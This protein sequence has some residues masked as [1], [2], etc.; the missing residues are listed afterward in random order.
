MNK[1]LTRL[2][3]DRLS[4]TFVLFAFALLQL[5]TFVSYVVF[6]KDNGYLPSPF[7]YVKSDTFMD[8]FNPMYWS[9]N[10]G[11]YTEWFSVY[12]P[13]VFIILRVIKFF[14]TESYASIDP[15]ELRS[16]GFFLEI[17]LITLILVLT[18]FVLRQKSWNVFSKTEKILLFICF[19]MSAP[20]LFALERGNTIII[21]LFLLAYSLSNTISK[22]T[23]LTL[24]A[25][26]INIKPYFV[27]LTISYLI[28]RKWIDFLF[29]MGVAGLLFLVTGALI[30][31]NFFLFFSN[32]LNFSNS[33][34]PISLRE[35]MT[36]P[37]SISVYSLVLSSESFCVGRYSD[38]CE[39]L[40]FLPSII[41]VFKWFAIITG[42]TFLTR[43]YKC[44]SDEE[45]MAFLVVLIS[46]MSV[47]VGGYSFLL[48]FAVF[49]VI[50][51]MEFRLYYLFFLAFIYSSVSIR[52][53]SLSQQDVQ[54][55]FLSNSYV[56][57]LWSLDINYLLK[58]AVNFLFFLLFVYEIYRR[59]S[60]LKI[61][62]HSEFGCQ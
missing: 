3:N 26:L 46:N 21:G 14:I 32:V 5:I 11:K 44:V 43:R 50:R 48:Y 22:A 59:N 13:L 2:F 33:N 49:P 47:S 51:S 41:E 28:K 40:N 8:L 19:I 17:A 58:P 61:C 60:G 53:I 27:L 42:V 38:F 56:A 18:C 45:I 6:F 30:D 9:D 54:Y 55:S 57:P 10:I 4:F 1:V 36:L 29:C 35:I 20:M 12:P 34:K 23:R 16:E 31:D 7:F 25:I 37:S 24:I 62:K 52:I 39:H 15:S